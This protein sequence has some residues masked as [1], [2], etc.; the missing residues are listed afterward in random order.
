MDLPVAA[1]P[2]HFG[3][4]TRKTRNRRVMGMHIAPLYRLLCAAT[5]VG[6]VLPPESSMFQSTF[7][8]AQ[9]D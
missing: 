7:H 2:Q 5:P 6:A 4:N 1:W 3:V 9:D 8:C